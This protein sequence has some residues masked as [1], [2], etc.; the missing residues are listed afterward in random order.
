MSEPFRVAIAG[1]GTVGS[2]VA[3]MLRQPG[4]PWAVRSGRPI[5]VVA[6]S[7]RDRRKDRGVDLGDIYAAYV[8]TMTRCGETSV[9]A[10]SA[11]HVMRYLHLV[12]Q[13]LERGGGA[14]DDELATVVESLEPTAGTR[15]MVFPV[16]TLPSFELALDASLALM[17]RR[18]DA[19]PPSSVT[20]PVGAS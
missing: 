14:G 19:T 7:A 15:P 13:E 18:G 5:E 1:L 17:A 10:S 4:G 11:W 2:R 20:G 16:T 9:W 6:V 8:A 12:C 3:A